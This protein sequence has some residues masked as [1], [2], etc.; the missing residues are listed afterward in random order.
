MDDLVRLGQPGSCGTRGSK[1]DNSPGR[2]ACQSPVSRSNQI[3]C[4]RDALLNW[5]QIISLTRGSD[6]V[7]ERLHSGVEHVGES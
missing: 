6:H 3:V 7:I 2:F 5:S 4:K 1:R